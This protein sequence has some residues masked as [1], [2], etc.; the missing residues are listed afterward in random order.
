MFNLKKYAG[1]DV[2]PQET[3]LEPQRESLE[4]VT[5]SYNALLE[6][7]RKNPDDGK[8]I[9]TEGR[10]YDVRNK[11]KIT[12]T[13]EAQLDNHNPGKNMPNRTGND[14]HDQLP[15]N[16]LEEVAH[17][18]KIKA[19]NSATVKDKDTE[20]WDAVL[21]SHEVKKTP[22]QLHNHPDRFK[23]LSR[24]DV[25]KNEGVRDMVMASLKDAD[26]ML[27]HIYRVAASERRDLS[28]Q[29]TELVNGITADKIKIVETFV[30]K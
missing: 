5:G 8:V 13:T 11:E 20:F 12:E 16:L 30:S 28:E 23:N 10:L 7:V 26:A 22:T 17:Q 25:L 27:Y 9:T 3:A 2:E 6:K 21:T 4:K 19:F 15:I 14:S 24:N 1:K 18:E 29:E